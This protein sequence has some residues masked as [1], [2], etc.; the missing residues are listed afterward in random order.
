MPSFYTDDF[1]DA[2]IVVRESPTA[3]G[4]DIGETPGTAGTIVVGQSIVNTIDVSGDNDWFGIN[5]VAGQTYQFS[6]NGSSVGGG[7]LSDPLLRL[8]SG[9]GLYITVDD[10]GG[11]GLNSLL[12]F[13]ATS[14]GTFYISAQAYVNQAGVGGTGTYTLSVQAVQFNPNDSWENSPNFNSPLLDAMSWGQRFDHT[15]LTVYFGATGYTA[16]GVTSEGFNAWEIQQFQAAF[17]A[18]SAVSGLTFTIVN[19]GVDADL[20]MILD[21]NELSSSLYGQFNPPGY[22]G[23]GNDGVGQFNGNLWD[24][25]ANGD[26]TVGGFGF[27]IIM[28]ELLHGLGLSHPHDT[29]GDSS[30]LPGVGSARGDY[31]D[32]NLSQGIFSVM[33]YNPAY[34]TGTPGSDPAN[35]TG[36]GSGV[37]YGYATGPMA[38]DIGI[39]QALYGANTTYASGN[40]TYFL[41]T[42]TGV[43]TYWSTIWDT[44]GIDS[45]RHTGVG[46]AQIDLRAA[47]LEMENGGGGFVSAVDGTRG[48]FTIANGVI[49]ENAYGGSSNDYL[50]GNA[51][52]NTLVGYGG[53]DTIVGGGG[54]DT[55]DGGNGADSLYGGTGNDD[56]TGSDGFDQLYGEAGN[57]T[58]RGGSTADRLYGGS[59]DDVLFGGSNFGLTVDGLWGDA[60]N[61]T[62]F[63]EGGFDL[64]DGGE[65]DDYLDGGLQADNLYGRVGED[66]LLGGDGLDRLFGGADDDIANGG[67]GNDGIFGEQGNDTLLGDSGNDRF[68]GGTGNDEIFG[69][70]DNDTVFAGAGFD[71]ITGGTGNDRLQG[72]FN[73]DTFVFGLGHGNDT[74][75]DFDALNVFERIDLSAINTFVNINS[76]LANSVQS[77]ANVI[78]NTGGGNTIQ[79]NGVLR[80]DLDSSDFI[81]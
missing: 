60:G 66:T 33:S 9:S 17:A 26:L 81:F 68:F 7:T 19:S 38:V 27:Y 40:D 69:G 28:H 67:A 51:V 55:I 14:S 42:G 31:G 63:G 21:T 8:Y 4:P 73:A 30:V 52:G 75:T 5:L 47:T 64:L 49:I 2:D 41:P 72:D 39:L 70:S 3:I 58:L 20:E 79:L 45:I 46:A 80:V 65:G 16:D 59:D 48:G 71:T 43:G 6:L 15:N 54:N 37:N 76:V 36:S 50:I 74:I 57:D 25:F 10:D 11:P 35:G 62:L 56:I 29:G 24:R 22:G 1:I 34:H 23:E 44:G 78:I 77:G 61:D 53:F 18:V 13:T 32:Y 12:T